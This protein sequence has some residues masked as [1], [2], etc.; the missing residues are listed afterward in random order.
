LR[1]TSY[2][3]HGYVFR[4]SDLRATFRAKPWYREDPSYAETRLTPQDAD[5]IRHVQDRERRL[6]A[7]AG[8]EALRDFELRSRARAYEA[9]H[10]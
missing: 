10:H 5:N 4:A 2:A 3:R 9:I 1:N 7:S 8:G 6:L